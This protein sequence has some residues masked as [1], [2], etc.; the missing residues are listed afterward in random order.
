MVQKKFS[1]TGNLSDFTNFSTNDSR[2]YHVFL[3]LIV[4]FSFLT[5]CV[6]LLG[7]YQEGLEKRK[8]PDTKV[9][10]SLEVTGNSTVK[11]SFDNFVF[12][13]VAATTATNDTTLTASQILSQVINATPTGAAAYTLRTGAQISADILSE[14]GHTMVEGDSFD[15]VINNLSTT[16]AHVITLT[17]AATGTT[18]VGNPLIY[19]KDVASGQI[20]VGSGAFRF[21]CTAADT[22]TVTR[23]A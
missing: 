6:V 13:T 1:E 11:G 14:K 22:Y 9:H 18:L 23:I 21:R 12:Q 10:G 19:P 5:V 2:G 17:T 8:F 3:L 15:L 20:T 7:G 16:T 4:L